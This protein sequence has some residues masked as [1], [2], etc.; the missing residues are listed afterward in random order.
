VID[1]F[2]V[3]FRCILGDHVYVVV[4]QVEVLELVRALDFKVVAHLE[5]T[6]GPLPQQAFL[7]VRLK[8]DHIPDDLFY[9]AC[10]NFINRPSSGWVPYHTHL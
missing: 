1:P 5:H 4:M 3:D 6:N 8:D 7:G 10:M 9:I 2:I